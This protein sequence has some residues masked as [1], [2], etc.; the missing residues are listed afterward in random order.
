MKDRYQQVEYPGRCQVSMTYEAPCMVV[1][2]NTRIIC[3]SG[4]SSVYCHLVCL[5][6]GQKRQ[7]K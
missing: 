4:V 1:L 6:A 3:P 7:E 5:T 2:H